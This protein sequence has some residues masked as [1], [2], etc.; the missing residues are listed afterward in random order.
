MSKV[1]KNDVLNNHTTCMDAFGFCRMLVS[2][3]GT[4]G[5]FAL[6]LIHEE[7]TDNPN[8]TVKR[9]LVFDLS[10]CG[11]KALFPLCISRQKSSNCI[12]NGG[13]SNIH[14]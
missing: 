9:M 6:S 12:C 10:V 11:S 14:K 3:D 1:I 5:S 13:S 8:N 2:V 7:F 4:T